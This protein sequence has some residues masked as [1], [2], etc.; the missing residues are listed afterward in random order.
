MNGR[1]L[2][3]ALS[4]CALAGCEQ[5]MHDMYDQPK[6]K[7][8]AP[9]PLFADG[10]SARTPPPGS[11]PMAQGAAA[12]TASGRHGQMPLLPPPGPALPLDEQGRSLARGEVG[13]RRYA[14]PLP[15]TLALLERG[16]ERFDI[17]CAP[18]HGASGS[19]DGMIV[20]RGFPAPPSY[21]T[22]RL[23]NAPDSH[24]YQVISDGY[25]VM[26]PYADRIGPHDRW[27]I[28]AYIR[29]LQLSQHAP[30]DRL[31]PQDL[32]RLPA[33]PVEGGETR[34]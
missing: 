25:G 10:N 28:V 33:T 3:L 27:A 24:F 34:R 8:L 19:G 13:E 20:R 21:H 16:R 22:D 7:P 17:Y 5:A 23:R 18:C 4:L 30:R 31:S 12:D 32:A 9:S 26:Y 11:V 29:A 6:Y 14:N 2:V 15:V 1:R